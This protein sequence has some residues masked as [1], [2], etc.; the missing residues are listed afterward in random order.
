MGY[1]IMFFTYTQVK[2]NATKHQTFS[3]K[4]EKYWKLC[5]K[6]FHMFMQGQR[7][8][9]IRNP[10]MC[11][12]SLS[13]QQIFLSHMWSCVPISKLGTATYNKCS[14]QKKTY[15]IKNNKRH[16][17]F[18]FE[19][20]QKKILTERTKSILCICQLLLNSVHLSNHGSCQSFS[21]PIAKLQKYLLLNYRRTFS[22]K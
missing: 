14:P 12:Q 4:D 15:L 13:D 20:L 17:S 7:K 11:Q 5:S 19:P 16:G 18:F 21:A 2:K 8:A 3:K 9:I 22:S 1:E 10:W 6:T